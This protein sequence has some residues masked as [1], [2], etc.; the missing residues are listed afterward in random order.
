MRALK[1]ALD[2]ASQGV[3]IRPERGCSSRVF[4]PSRCSC[5]LTDGN[6]LRPA[7]AKPPM[8]ETGSERKYRYSLTCLS[9]NKLLNNAFFPG[10]SWGRECVFLC[11]SDTPVGSYLAVGE[12][13]RIFREHPQASSHCVFLCVYLQKPSFFE[14]RVCVSRFMH[15]CES[16]WACILRRAPFY[17][18][19]FSIQKLLS[20][21]PS[22]CPHTH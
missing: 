18:L 20:L 17:P 7:I 6:R 4:E 1:G 11:V 14:Q 19:L 21:S 16:H 10:D 15:M 13:N 2:G 22:L 8:H 12:H 3:N 9:K 5:K